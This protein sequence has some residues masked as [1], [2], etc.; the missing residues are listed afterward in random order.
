MDCRFNLK[1][2]GKKLII[3]L[4]NVE[5]WY[6]IVCPCYF[7]HIDEC[8]HSYMASVW[9]SHLHHMSKNTPSTCSNL[10]TL[11]SLYNFIL[12]NHEKIIM[13]HYI[14]KTFAWQYNKNNSSEKS[15]IFFSSSKIY[16]VNPVY[17]ER[18]TGHSKYIRINRSSYYVYSAIVAGKSS[19]H[20]KVFAL[21]ENSVYPS[22]L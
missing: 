19:R 2:R 11:L 8:P 3:Y 5:F 4:G 14:V 1:E 13:W 22:S 6:M 12:K 17:N 10:P 15:S 20:E 18:K 21:T 7:H 9:I 16:T